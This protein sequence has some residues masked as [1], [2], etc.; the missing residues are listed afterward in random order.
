VDDIVAVFSLL[1]GVVSVWLMVVAIVIV[2]VIV[3]ANAN[4]AFG[5]ALV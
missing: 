4:D 2:I 5:F 3:I 1:N